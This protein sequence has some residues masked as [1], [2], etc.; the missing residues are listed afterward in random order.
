MYTV[1]VVFPCARSG[2]FIIK[3]TVIYLHQ[4]HQ[5]AVLS[6]MYLTAVGFVMVRWGIYIHDS[7]GLDFINLGFAGGFLT[8]LFWVC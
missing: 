2:E 4:Y 3:T 6:T 8:T 5:T 1:T 7:D